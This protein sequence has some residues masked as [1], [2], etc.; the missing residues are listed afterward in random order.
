MQL[1]TGHS[2]LYKHQNTIGKVNSPM[3]PK[4]KLMNETPIHFIEECPFYNSNRL[5]VFQS[6]IVNLKDLVEADDIHQIAKFANMTKRF[7][8]D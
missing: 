8:N 5:D 2:M 3:C 4:C 6:H 7:I 1:L